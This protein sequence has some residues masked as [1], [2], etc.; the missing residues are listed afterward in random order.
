MI[1]ERVGIFHIRR[2]VDFARLYLMAYF[3]RRRLYILS[4]NTGQALWG[5]T[6]QKIGLVSK[7]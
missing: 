5:A 7:R 2:L 3:L 1:S 4:A 6:G